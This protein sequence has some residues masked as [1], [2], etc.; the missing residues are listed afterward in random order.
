MKNILPVIKKKK[1]LYVF[2]DSFFLILSIDSYCLVIE[3]N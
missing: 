1:K 3:T 2:I